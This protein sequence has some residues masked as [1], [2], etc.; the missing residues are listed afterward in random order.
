M[1]W[2]SRRPTVPSTHPRWAH[3]PMR[4][5]DRYMRWFDRYMRWLDLHMRWCDRPMRWFDRPTRRF[6]RPMRWFDRP[7]RWFDRSMRRFD[8]SMRCF[9]PSLR[10]HNPCMRCNRSLAGRGVAT[11]RRAPTARSLPTAAS[12]LALSLP[13]CCR[14]GRSNAAES[15]SHLSPSLSSLA[16]GSPAASTRLTPFHAVRAPRTSTARKN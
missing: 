11:P 13:L 2:S 4:W 16:A 7:L 9:N 6:D 5:F 10:W 8:R 14:S 12:T 1:I 3:P 15:P